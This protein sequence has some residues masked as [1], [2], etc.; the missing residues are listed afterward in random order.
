ML[1]TERAARLGPTR[2]HLA[3]Q[4]LR[5]HSKLLAVAG[6][7]AAGVLAVVVLPP[8]ARLDIK[9]KPEQL[10]AVEEGEEVEEGAGADERAVGLADAG[11][12]DV[13]ASAEAHPTYGV[14]GYVLG[15][16]VPKKPDPGQKRPPCNPVFERAINGA[17]WYH[18]SELPPPCKD[19]FEHDGQCYG[20][21][22]PPGK[23]RPPTSEEP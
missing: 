2:W 8:L 21:V 14:P 9:E 10:V 18:V 5:R 13:L 12:D 16:P 17:C 4:A 22:M 15:E 20:P 11:V 1:P 3:R 19:Y 23:A 6:A 7:L